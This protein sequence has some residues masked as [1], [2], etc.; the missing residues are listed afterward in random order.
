MVS[1]FPLRAVVSRVALSTSSRATEKPRVVSGS[2]PGTNADSGVE[3]GS[4]SAPPRGSRHSA[5]NNVIT[6]GG[7]AGAS[8]SV[9]EMCFKRALESDASKPTTTVISARE[10]GPAGAQTNGFDFAFAFDDASSA[11]HAED[12]VSLTNVAPRTRI[13]AACAF[14]S[15]SASTSVS[16]TA[17]ATVFVSFVSFFGSVGSVVPRGGC[18]AP[19]RVVARTPAESGPERRVAAA[20]AKPPTGPKDASDL[21][22]VCAVAAAASRANS[23]RCTVAPPIAATAPPGSAA[24]TMRAS[25]AA[26]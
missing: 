18:C 15:G 2:A 25:A 23:A 26:R 22:A 9:F 1:L 20:S 5:R 13:T 7:T 19:S 21:A 11:L 24:L 10:Y 8:T 14:G 4:S 6:A 16:S 17:P 12:A 3:V